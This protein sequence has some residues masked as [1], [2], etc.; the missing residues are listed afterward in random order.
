MTLPQCQ[1]RAMPDG[2]ADDAR[3]LSVM[4]L[5][6]KYRCGHRTVRRWLDSLGVPSFVAQ[7]H[8]KFKT[9]ED[10]IAVAPTMLKQDMMAHYGVGLT[11]INRWLNEC[12]VEAKSPPPPPRFRK[13]SH[14]YVLMQ[15]KPEAAWSIYMNA[16]HIL[17]RERFIVHRCNERGAFDPDGALWRVGNVI[18][19]DEEI[20]AR[21]AKYERIAA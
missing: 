3:R 17:R 9:P 15:I 5:R 21:A 19:T 20:V 12:G 4:Q 18:C 13:N 2:F 8:N 11:V 16:A 14:G 6:A 10:F 7:P 1:P